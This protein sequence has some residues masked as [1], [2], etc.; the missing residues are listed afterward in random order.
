[1]IDIH[2]HILPMVDD[3]SEDMHMSIEMARMYIENGIKTVIATPHYI[4]GSIATSLENNRTT[5]KELRMELEKEKIDLEV[6]LGNEAY[7]SLDLVKDIEE[8]KVSTLNG[9][10][11]ILIEL[12]MHD[13]PLYVEDMIFELLLKGYTPII[14]HPERNTKIMED[15]NILYNYIDKGALAQLNLPSIEG[16]YGEEVKATAGILLKHNMIHFLG[17]DSH[18]NR[19][20]SPKVKNSLTILETIVSDEDMEYLRHKNAKLLLENKIIDIK[21]PIKYNPR[22]QKSWASRALK[23]ISNIIS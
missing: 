2:S 7:I 14:A 8:G 6:L 11:Y 10:R 21:T 15:P 20:R 19:G 12:P 18:T 16:R 22:R 5:L 4:D 17:T 9:T 3:G 13:I 1:M 23:K